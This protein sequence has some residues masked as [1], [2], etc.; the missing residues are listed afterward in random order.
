MLLLNVQSPNYSPNELV[1]HRDKF[2]TSNNY[3]FHVLSNPLFNI[4]L[5]PL[6]V[7]NYTPAI[8]DNQHQRIDADSMEHLPKTL[9]QYI[10]DPNFQT[11]HLMLAVYALPDIPVAGS[12]NVFE[13]L[14]PQTQLS[15]EITILDKSELDKNNTAYHFWSLVKKEKNNELYLTFHLV[16]KQEKLAR[17]WITNPVSNSLTE[18]FHLITMNFVELPFR[19]YLYLR[20]DKEPLTEKKTRC[21]VDQQQGDFF[22][23]E[24]LKRHIPAYNYP[25]EHLS[26]ALAQVKLN[27]IYMECGV[28]GGRTISHIAKEYPNQTIHGFD[29]FEGLSEEWEGAA[30]GLFSLDGKMPKVPSNV[31]LHKGW[32]D[33]TLPDFEQNLPENQPIT[34]LHID[35]DLYSSAQTIFTVMRKRIIPGTIIVFDDFLYNRHWIMHEPKAFVEFLRETDY[36]FTYISHT[37]C[38]SVAVEIKGYGEDKKLSYWHQATKKINWRFYQLCAYFMRHAR[39]VKQALFGTTP[40]LKNEQPVTYYPMKE[41]A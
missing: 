22:S 14:T 2:Q 28:H 7:Y 8:V 1:K 35:S 41:R 25:R 29:S 11:K 26:Y 16:F 12:R 6:A 13:S 40:W 33:K 36:S 4:K 24:M 34:F 32:F 39:P 9:E 18:I 38:H 23:T 3:T 20:Y 30:P 37:N 19:P 21:L 31:I 10:L 27:G 17:E 15:E 5:H